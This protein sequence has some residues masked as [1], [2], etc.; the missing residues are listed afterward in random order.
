MRSALTLRLALAGFGVVVCALAAWVF[1]VVHAPVP[2]A[3]VALV[4]L[5]VVARRKR[6]GEPG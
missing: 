2:A 1:V 4:D 6:H 3:V 5:V